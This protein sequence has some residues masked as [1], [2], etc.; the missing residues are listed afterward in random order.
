MDYYE[1]IDR[2][3]QRE[4]SLYERDLEEGLITLDEYNQA[5]KRLEREAR[6][7]LAEIERDGSREW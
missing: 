1:Q 6:Q 2:A 5:V 7:E 3:L 4:I